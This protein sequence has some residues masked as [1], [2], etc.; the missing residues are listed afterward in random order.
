VWIPAALAAEISLL[1]MDPRTGKT[2]WGAWNTLITRLLR[3]WVESQRLDPKEANIL[4]TTSFS[5][6]KGVLDHE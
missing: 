4:S 2:K 5:E 3:D 6:M 1:L